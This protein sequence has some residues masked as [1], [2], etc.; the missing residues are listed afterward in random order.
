MS[1][2]SKSGV[3]DP[4]GDEDRRPR[5]QAEPGKNAAASS[6]VETP[7]KRITLLQSALNR[8]LEV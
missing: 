6:G 2:A 5:G 3:Y 7:A 4:L 1:D 8:A